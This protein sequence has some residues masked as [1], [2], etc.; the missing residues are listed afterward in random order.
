MRLWGPAFF[1]QSPCLRHARARCGLSMLRRVDAPPLSP[2]TPQA[3]G[4]AERRGKLFEE[5]KAAFA[6]GD[7]AKAK[8]L[9][10]E[11]KKQ[12]REAATTRASLSASAGLSSAHALRPPPYLHPPPPPSKGELMEHANKRAASLAFASSAANATGDPNTIDLHGLHVKE[13]LSLVKARVKALRRATALE[14]ARPS[15]VVI[16]GRGSHSAD[17]LAR[18]KPAVEELAR[19]E[20]LRF[21]P[22]EPNPG[23]VTIDFDV[24]SDTSGPGGGLPGCAVM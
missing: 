6:R 10:D 4:H 8:S 13:A 22:D 16:T 7:K 23:C 24:D 5:S 20:K 1:G 14:G 15:L 19:Q 17:G 9:S 21:R 11:G 18:I 3:S 12:V 2:P